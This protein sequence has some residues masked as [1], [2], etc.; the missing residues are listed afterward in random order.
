MKRDVPVEVAQVS[1]M[2]EGRP[3]P[4]TP[5]GH[6]ATLVRLIERAAAG[7]TTAFEQLMTLSQ[8]KVATTAWRLLGNTEDARDATQEVFLRVYRHLGRFKPEQ[9]FFGWLYRI[10]VNVCHDLERKRRPR[11]VRVTSLEEERESGSLEHLARDEDG[12]GATLLAQRRALVARAMATLPS[13]ER[14]AVVLRDIEGLSTEEVAEVM[15]SRPATVR[16]QISSA[17]SKI[18]QYCDRLLKGRR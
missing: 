5:A 10:T 1:L 13:K 3:V 16:S 8:H 11:G 9:D 4:E 6:N 7:E 12:E 2:T 17:R 18:K 15:G 14:A